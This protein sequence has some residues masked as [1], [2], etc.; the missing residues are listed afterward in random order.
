MAADKI[1][2]LQGTLDMLILKVLAPQPLHGLGVS[3]PIEQ[4]TRNLSGQ[5]GFPVSCSAPHG[6]ARL[7][8]RLLGAAQKTNSAPGIT[9]SPRP[10]ATS[11]NR[12]STGSN[13]CGGYGASFAVQLNQQWKRA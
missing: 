11:L 13:N 4:I 12:K 10:D 5:A 3:R 2:L 8:C 6:R 9:I 1:D 7:D